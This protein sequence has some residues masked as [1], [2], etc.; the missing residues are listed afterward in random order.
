M[1]GTLPQV[2]EPSAAATED[3]RLVRREEL[4]NKTTVLLGGRAA[5][6]RYAARQT[7]TSIGGCAISRFDRASMPSL[8]WK[9]CETAALRL[10]GQLCVPQAFCAGTSQVLIPPRFARLLLQRKNVPD[11]FPGVGVGYLGVGWHMPR[12]GSVRTFSDR[13]GENRD[14]PRI[15][16]VPGGDIGVRRARFVFIVRVTDIALVLLQKDLRSLGTGNVD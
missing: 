7:R 11:H 1:Q 15:L 4:E 14:R 6:R 10:T 5:D 3:R 13:G 8:P 16:P 2:R 9:Q 12:P